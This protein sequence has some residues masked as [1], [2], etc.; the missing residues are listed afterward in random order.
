MPFPKA[1]A[2]ETAGRTVTARLR[3][4]ADKAFADIA[5]TWHH[6]DG[7][8]QVF[9][10][11]ASKLVPILCGKHKPTYT[12]QHDQGDY[13]VVTNVAH[14]VLTGK[15]AELKR[16]YRHSGYP[17]GLRITKF[18]ELF[19]K[20]PVEPFR[21]AVYGMLPKN[22]LRAQRMQRLRL[23]PEDEHLHH[24]QLAAEGG[25]RVHFDPAGSGFAPLAVEPYK[26]KKDVR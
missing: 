3:P 15:K 1:R 4:R 20:N 11:L 23:F 21:R 22:K 13:V 16:Y 9:G 7:Y 5:R 10:R 18:P 25:R 14:M 2:I 26:E 12:P 19:A 8:G 17:G 6:V 24:E